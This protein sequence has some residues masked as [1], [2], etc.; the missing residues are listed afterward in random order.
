MYDV[1]AQNKPVNKIATNPATYPREQLHIDA[2]GPLPLAM[3]RKE[4]SLKI[5]D[6][7]SG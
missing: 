7:F 6:E 4:Y 5:R 2:S 3:G 1:E